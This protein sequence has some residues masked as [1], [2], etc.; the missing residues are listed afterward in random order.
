LQQNF[1][2]IDDLTC[3]AV[4]IFGNSASSEKTSVESLSL[5]RFQQG[6]S[7]DDRV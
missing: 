3:R 5:K 1:D 4:A 2:S 6:E 7:R